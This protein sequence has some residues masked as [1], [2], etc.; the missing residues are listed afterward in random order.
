MGS[1]KI[2]VTGGAGFIGSHLV[3]ALIEDGHKVR[4]FDNLD[5]QVHGVG[6][7]KP[8]YLNRGAEFIKGDVRNKAALEK[9]MKGVDM[10]FHQAAKVGVG[11][12]MYQVKEYVDVNIGGTSNL[13]DILVNT[14]NKVKKLI[15]A[16]SMSSYGEGAYICPKCGP[17][18]PELRIKKDLDAGKWEHYCQGCKGEL[19]PKPTSED[20]ALCSTS[21]YAITKKVQ[22]EMAMSISKAYK[23]PAVSL[24]YFNVYGTRQ[25]LS[26]P[27]TGVAAIF[28]S[29][30]KNNN[31]PV[32]YEDGNQT[33]DFVS[34][35]D[36]VQSNILAMS[37]P[38]AD[39]EIFNVSGGTPISISNVSSTLMG[40]FG[41]SIKSEITNKYR[42]GDIRHCTADISKIKNKLGFSPKVSLEKG[43]KELVDWSAGEKAVDKFEKAAKE[44]IKKGLV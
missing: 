37:K 43:F 22:E 1:L 23:I 3:D 40:L 21:I 39:Y 19:M 4:I 33:R 12:S 2:L 15:V 17:M 7:R 27:Y 13:L 42:Q 44:L 14:K 6:S 8:V 10:I 30:I 29:R 11:Q 31:P 25:S 41:K 20:K 24:R 32:I 28:I 34:V 18:Y 36:I 16:A 35:Y 26:N 38:E 5:S 9:A